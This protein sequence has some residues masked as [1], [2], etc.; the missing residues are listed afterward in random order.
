[1]GDESNVVGLAIGVEHNRKM[2][3]F[4]IARDNEHEASKN[5]NVNGAL[6]AD[7]ARCAK[8]S[9]CGE[10]DLG[11]GTEGIIEFKRQMGGRREPYASVTVEHRLYAPAFVLWEGLKQSRKW[12]P[13]LS[14]FSTHSEDG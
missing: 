13:S 8:E 9:G 6:I 7:M 2:Y 4:I 14:P 10:Y 11:G 1:M 12:R 3:S 5:L